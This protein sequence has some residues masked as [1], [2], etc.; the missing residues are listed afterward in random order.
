MKKTTTALLLLTAMS[1]TGCGTVAIMNKS[2]AVKAQPEIMVKTDGDFWGLGKEGTFNMAGQ[3]HGQYTRS[4]SNSTWF[5]TLS[6]KDGAM[7]ATI[8]RN[9]NN[10]TWKLV[11]S[12]GGVSVNYMGVSL[13][14]NDPYV[15]DIHQ[16]D[17]KVGE[18]R[19]EPQNSMINIGLA[20]SETGSVRIGSTHFN[21]E[22][23][24]TGEGMIMPVEKAL[25][26]SFKR[27]NQ[28][29]GAAQTNGMITLQMLPDLSDNEKDLLAVATIASALSW[30]PEE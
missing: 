18:Y 17:K 19:I 12:G 20:Q 5:N 11:C 6:F 10:E 7:G 14:G 29:V 4:A 27:G 26:Y 2:D 30:R 28:E 16:N 15:C 24:H 8:T 23:I 21:I 22:T 25:G 9:D 13:G 1:L 3:Y